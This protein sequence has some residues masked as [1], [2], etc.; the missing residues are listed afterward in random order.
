MFLTT[1][2]FWFHLFRS[3]DKIYEDDTVVHLVLPPP[4]PLQ[5]DGK[6]DSTYTDLPLSPTHPAFLLAGAAAHYPRPAFLL[7]GAA[8]NYGSICGHVFVR[9]RER[10]GGQVLHH[11]I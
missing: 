2:T 4:P 6:G 10:G 1:F 3:A 9:W 8:A 11:P 5:R 7:A